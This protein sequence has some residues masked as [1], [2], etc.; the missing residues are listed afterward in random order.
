M[1][2]EPLISIITPNYNCATYIAQTIESVIA[3]TYQNWEML[4]QDDCSTDG[5]LEIAQSYAQKDSRI[6]VESNKSNVGAANSRNNAIRRSQG[7]YLSFLDSDDLWIPTKLEE[8]IKFMQ[9]NNCDFCYARYEH[10]NKKGKSMLIQAKAIK[11][12]TYNKLL[13]HCW[14]GCLTVIY[15]QDLSDKIYGPVLKN[16]NDHGLFLRVMPR[17]KNAMGM[18]KCL[19]LYRIREGGI[20]R[21]KTGKLSSF[22][23]LFHD[24]EGINYLLATFFLITQILVKKFYK[25]RKITIEESCTQYIKQ[26]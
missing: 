25:Y 7:T 26:I 9:T 22:Y 2:K 15:K 14:T 11:H 24:H 3:Q 21:K 18:D 23:K 16:C 6:K 4:I 13:F 10:I 20:S 19:G 1:D 12:L 17:I 5:S 8:Q